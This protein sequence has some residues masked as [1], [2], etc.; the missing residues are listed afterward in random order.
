MRSKMRTNYIIVV[1]FSHRRMKLMKDQQTVM[2]PHIFSSQN[3][4]G[5]SS[6]QHKR[7]NRMVEKMPDT[8]QFKEKTG[9]PSECPS[10]SE[11]IDQPLI[12]PMHSLLAPGTITIT[13]DLQR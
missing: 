8:M 13:R 2:I 7:G 5:A 3:V 10:F 12:S 6:Q 9:I 1:H 11:D 4:A